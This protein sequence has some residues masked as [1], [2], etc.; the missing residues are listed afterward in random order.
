MGWRRFFLATVTIAAVL[1]VIGV[2]CEALEVTS[3]A[4]GI[5]IPPVPA[6]D[7]V[8]WPWCRVPDLRIRKWWY[9]AP[10]RVGRDVDLFFEIEN[11]GR[12]VARGPILWEVTCH[13]WGFWNPVLDRIAV[14]YLSH[15]LWPGQ[16]K[17]VHISFR[18][19]RRTHN[20]MLMADPSDH[21]GPPDN[22]PFG[23]KAELYGWLSLRDGHIRETNEK[24]NSKWVCIRV[25][26]V[27]PAEIL[28]IAIPVVN[29]YPEFA[30]EVVIEMDKEL[31]VP[32]VLEV[33][34]PG[35]DVILLDVAEIEPAFVPLEPGQ[36]I[37]RFTFD[38]RNDEEK[39]VLLARLLGDGILEKLVSFK[40]LGTATGPDGEPIFAEVTVVIEMETQPEEEEALE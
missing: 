13:D 22:P 1:A 30:T 20:L 19:T 39:V 35:G 31:A 10:P 7:A 4:T 32:P 26:R 8:R 34:V 14:S 37:A 33:G 27:K 17:V 23:Q 25:L 21:L 28:E 18:M 24:N 16:S 9:K 40:V 6:P 5:D 3:R 36:E 2:D 38:P 12:G 11:V 15:S 29:P